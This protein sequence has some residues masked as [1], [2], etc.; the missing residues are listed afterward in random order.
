MA[1]SG[2]PLSIV[3]RK[4][5]QRDVPQIASLYAKCFA[6]WIDAPSAPGYMSNMIADP[7][8][9]VIAAE[10]KPG[11]LA[12]FIIANCS[13]ARTHE[14]VNIDVMAVAPDCRRG[15]LGKGL[16][17]MGE[18]VAH[19]AGARALTLQVVESNEPAKNLYLGLGFN[20][21]AKRAGYYRDGTNAY[22]M[23]K[24]LPPPAANDD[25]SHPA[26]QRP[27]RKRGHWSIFS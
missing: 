6:Q 16:M 13:F 18:L 11:H 22:E 7:D 2:T 5:A 20:I 19:N 10:D 27:Q 15:G 26:V 3:F 1:D 12:G 14:V 4:A 25:L 9:Q 21:E 8:F 23:Q 17:H 24:M